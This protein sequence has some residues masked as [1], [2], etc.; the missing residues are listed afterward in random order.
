[1][2]AFSLILQS[3]GSEPKELQFDKAEISVGRLPS[4]DITLTQSNVSKQHARIVLREGKYFIIDRKSTNGTFVNGD[5]ISAPVSLKS[6]DKI[7]IGDFVM[8]FLLSEDKGPIKSADKPAAPPVPPPLPAQQQTAKEAIEDAGFDLADDLGL[9]EAIEEPAPE[10][11]PEPEPEMEPEMEEEE[12]EEG[13]GMNG[14][15]VL[16]WRDEVYEGSL[17][18]D[19]FEDFEQL[20]EYHLDDAEFTSTISGKLSEMI[21]RLLPEE[22][23]VDLKKS[24]HAVVLEELLGYGPLE[25]YLFDEDVEEISINGPGLVF[26]RSSGSKFQVPECFTSERSL[27]NI[28]ARLV[29]ASGLPFDGDEPFIELNLPEGIKLSAVMYPYSAYGTSI[30]ILK[31]SSQEVSEDAMI[32]EEVLTDEMT[33]TLRAAIAD[34]KNIMVIASDERDS[35]EVLELLTEYIPDDDRLMLINTGLE[36]AMDKPDTVL[37]DTEVADVLESE[38]DISA[39]GMIRN[40]YKMRPDRLIVHGLDE[41]SALELLYSIQTEFRGSLFTL[42]ASSLEDA[43]RNMEI[44]ATFAEG[45]SGR[46]AAVELMGCVVNTVVQIKRFEDGS[47]RMTNIAEVS[48]TDDGFEINSIHYYDE[49]KGEFTKP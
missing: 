13:L 7:Y 28:L 46:A 32:A 25:K 36:V 30:Q 49:E 37:I 42:R 41:D 24:I 43:L 9:D 15:E 11:A 45:E 29:I 40:A 26:I 1:M 14:E 16:T 39:G 10:P 23:P 38:W 8:T 33:G 4:D 27:F 35:L 12:E 31:P 3:G 21:D 17:D 6:S 48:E 34:K 47:R 2:A 19:E 18:F 20:I 5:R 22:V 44:M